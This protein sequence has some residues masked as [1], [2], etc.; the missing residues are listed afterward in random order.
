MRVTVK[1]NVVVSPGAPS[2]CADASALMLRVGA[3]PLIIFSAVTLMAST[4]TRS[5]RPFI[6]P[7]KRKRT[8]GLPIKLVRSMLSWVQRFSVSILP[9]KVR[10]SC[11]QDSPLSLEMSTDADSLLSKLR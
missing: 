2:G 11:V 1:R 10:L 4:L 8:S 3:A 5:F 9:R 7:R 6:V